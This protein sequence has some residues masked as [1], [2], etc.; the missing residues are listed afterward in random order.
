MQAIPSVAKPSQKLK[1]GQTSLAG[2]SHCLRPPRLPRCA[3]R[4]ERTFLV[5]MRKDTDWHGLDHSIDKAGGML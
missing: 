1:C 4:K 5:P 3:S 2:Q